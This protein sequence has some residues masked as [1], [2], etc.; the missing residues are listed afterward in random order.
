VSAVDYE[1]EM[2]NTKVISQITVAL[3]FSFLAAGVVL[4]PVAYAFD[5]DIQQRLLDQA[6]NGDGVGMA[7]VLVGLPPCSQE[8][9]LQNLVDNQLSHTGK[10]GLNY[11]LHLEADTNLDG[12]RKDVLYKLFIDRNSNLRQLRMLTIEVNNSCR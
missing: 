7:Q 3:M 12:S 2:K 10:D 6:N 5:Q 11:R 4:S 9:E 1:G 8:Q